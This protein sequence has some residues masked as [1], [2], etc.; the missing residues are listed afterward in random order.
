[1]T[2]SAHSSGSR[3]LF[4]TKVDFDVTGTDFECMPEADPFST[5]TSG[6]GSQRASASLQ[7]GH[8]LGGRF[9]IRRQIGMGGMGVVYQAYDRNRKDDI[10]IKVMLPG[11]TSSE[12]AKQR[13]INEAMIAIK[14]AHQNIVNTYDVLSE[15]EYLYITMELLEGRSLRQDM[16]AKKRTNRLYTE[17]EALEMAHAL[18]DALEYAHDFTTH[19]DIKPENIWLTRK[20]R[21]K[22]MDF[23]IARMLNG[24]QVHQSTSVL[25]TA[26]YMAPEQLSGSRNVDNRA[27]QYSLGVMLYEL[28]TGQVPTGRSKSVRQQRG[29]VSAVV[30][31][32]ID[33]ALEPD[34]QDRHPDMRAFANALG[35]VKQSV[36]Q[37]N[38]Q[39]GRANP[40]KQN[41]KTVSAGWVDWINQH[42]MVVGIGGALWGTVLV[43]AYLS[44]QNSQKEI[45]ASWVKWQSE[46]S[47]AYDHAESLKGSPDERLKSWKQFLAIYNKDNPFSTADEKLR[48]QAETNQQET[49]VEVKEAKA[50]TKANQYQMAKTQA[51]QQQMR[52][53]Q[54]QQM[55]LQQQQMQMQQAQRDKASAEF[56]AA[57]IRGLVR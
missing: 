5:G 3:G 43:A 10:A 9:E 14:L 42:R 12:P 19:R 29:D 8:V 44:Y 52:A 35:G 20:D 1:M 50:T 56:G 21:V 24:S 15:G 49:E 39:T 34:P 33:R 13:F 37:T 16:E 22:L 46:M 17:A 25:G 41:N 23:G 55:Q 6:A 51:A 38:N 45:Q 4:T 26:Y 53:Q 30:S 47:A 32:A 7:A 31:D 28:L 36:S 11:L 18:C 54:Q 27:D 40:V 57:L 48:A 2:N